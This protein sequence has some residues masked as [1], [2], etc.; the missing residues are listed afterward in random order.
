M[1]DRAFDRVLQTAA[2]SC[3]WR[4][5]TQV[6][7]A[8]SA[9]WDSSVVVGLVR[10]KVTSLSEW[11]IADRVRLGALTIAWA[12]V[13]HL[14]SLF[15]LP[16]YVTSGL[17]RTWAAVGIVAA[18]VVAALPEGFARAWKDRFR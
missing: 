2:E 7:A 17:P 15:F 4:T 13:G 1:K 18:L 14:V 12:G 6:V 16:R 8:W 11:P 3:I 9:A 5:A 10:R